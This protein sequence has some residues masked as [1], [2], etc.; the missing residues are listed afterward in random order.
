MKSI[1]SYIL[2]ICFLFVS[3]TSLHSSNNDQ[4]LHK[5]DTSVSVFAQIDSYPTDYEDSEKKY[6]TLVYGTHTF[7]STLF[8]A[9]S[10]YFSN[11]KHLLKSYL[12]RAPPC[13]FPK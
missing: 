6:L 13:F 2:L 8:E 4:Q 10:Y 9:L 3:C 12:I 11:G 1:S 7:K 5:L